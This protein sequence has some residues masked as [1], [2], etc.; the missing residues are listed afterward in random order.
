MDAIELLENYKKRVD[1]EL[2]LFFDNKI[3]EAR[4]KHT[5]GEGAVQYIKDFTLSGGKRLRPAMMYYGFLGSGGVDGDNILEASMSI[6]LTHIFLLIHDDIID[7]DEKRH[8][9]KTL[10]ERYK[11]FGKVIL[12]NKKEAE[13][14]G[15]SMA[16]IAGDMAMMMASEI[17]FT[18]KF[19]EKNII[20]ALNALQAIAYNTI[21][22]EMLDV[23]ME[24]KG[25]STEKEVLEMNEAKTARYTFE[26]PMQLGYILQKETTNKTKKD[27]EGIS[28][29]ALPLGKA[30][31]IRD[32]I[33]GVF[34]DEKKLGKPVGSDILEGKQTLLLVKAMEWGSKKQKKELEKIISNDSISRKDIDFFRKIIRETGSLQ[35]S[36]DLSNRFVAEAK[37]ALENLDIKNKEAHAFFHGIADYIVKRQV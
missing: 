22:G 32:D 19:P 31:Q 26:G 18:S 28:A 27:L 17:L 3:K 10:H 30:F 1:K 4:K 21:P 9:V 14:F 24:A 37:E 15:N 12:Q 2:C 29:Y 36:L 16:M 35:Y 23:V 25:K 6:E 20:S 34:G 5:L 33:L 7:K 11:E 8:G 13:H